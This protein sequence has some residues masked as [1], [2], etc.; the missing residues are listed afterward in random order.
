VRW[1]P[2]GRDE[3]EGA[4]PSPREH[5]A[6]GHPGS[7]HGTGYRVHMHASIR[8]M[9]TLD[10]YAEAEDPTTLSRMR[11][12]APSPSLT[13]PHPPSHSL[14]TPSHSLT[15]PHAPS[16]SLTLALGVSGTRGELRVRMEDG[17]EG[18]NWWR[19]CAASASWVEMATRLQDDEV[20]GMERHRVVRAR[21]SMRAGPMGPE[22]QSDEC[23]MDQAS[24]VRLSTYTPHTPLPRP[25]NQFEVRGSRSRP[26]S[27]MAARACWMRGRTPRRDVSVR[28]AA[29]SWGRARVHCS[30]LAHDGAATKM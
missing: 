27:S 16:H 28:G 23:R 11:R 13:L 18:A 2:P 20:E 22:T 26:R 17:G 21:M 4:H 19:D 5:P 8:L 9:A 3:Q 29:W 12:C 6:N 24:S 7:L 10:L 25:V 1:T 30:P 14:H 15:L